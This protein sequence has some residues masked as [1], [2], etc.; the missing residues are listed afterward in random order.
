MNRI[1]GLPTS[2][3]IR[4]TAATL[5]VSL[6]LATTL[7]GCNESSESNSAT[8]AG[9]NSTAET[10][11]ENSSSD[12][13]YEAVFLDNDEIG[14]LFAE[15]RG[16]TP[17][18]DQVTKDFHVTTE[19]KPET[20]HPE[21]YGE[22]VVVHITSYA[23]QEVAMEDGSMTANEGFKAEVTSSNESL[24]SYFASLNKNYHITGAYKDGAKYT[25]Y[26][27][28]SQGEPLDVTVTGIFGGGLADGTIDL[29]GGQK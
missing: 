8:D 17:P 9:Q 23:V 21:W 14:N 10:S 27:D 28:F 16:E 24:N 12:V 11:A 18:F 13:I 15:M 25:E 3:Q 20:L 29:G 4:T 5:F 2:R 19:F 22:K 7:S 6:M 1:A 26:V